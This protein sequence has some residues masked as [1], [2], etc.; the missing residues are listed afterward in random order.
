M[1]LCPSFQLTRIMDFPGALSL[2][3][4]IKSYL[5][6]H[7]DESKTAEYHEPRQV[8]RLDLLSREL[9]IFRRFEFLPCA[10][11]KIWSGLAVDL[12]ERVH[13]RQ[14]LDILRKLARG[15]V[16]PLERRM[17]QGKQALDGRVLDVDPCER[18]TRQRRDIPNGRALQI[19]P[20]QRHAI[21]D[22]QISFVVNVTNIGIS[23]TFHNAVHT[24][25]TD[26]SSRLIGVQEA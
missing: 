7:D 6:R 1:L 19:E 14:D 13:L 8:K 25:D 2:V 9:V 24:R 4:S 10:A 5:Y 17:L 16:D 23:K 21:W 3:E 15:E 18:H 22:A 12:L 11:Q 20:C 26:V